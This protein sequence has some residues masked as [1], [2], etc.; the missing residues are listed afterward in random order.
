MEALHSNWHLP[1]NNIY[2]DQLLCFV[3]VG[4]SGHIR[5]WLEGDKLFF[6]VSGHYS[7]FT[8]YHLS[9]RVLRYNL[10]SGEHDQLE[11]TLPP[12]SEDEL[13]QDLCVVS[14]LIILIQTTDNQDCHMVYRFTLS[15]DFRSVSLQCF[16]PGTQSSIF[17]KIKEPGFFWTPV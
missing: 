8:F 6:I 3:M 13:F 14:S 11:L 10:I 9:N 7:Y 17:V 15:D 16:H 2:I 1:Q 5:F 12:H 4:Q